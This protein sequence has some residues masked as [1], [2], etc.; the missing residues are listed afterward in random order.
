MRAL[1][2]LVLLAACQVDNGNSG[3]SC[4][5]TFGLYCEQ[6]QDGLTCTHPEE[7]GGT[8]TCHCSSGLWECNDCPD[9][10]APVG[11][12]ST[13]ASCSV[14]GFENACACSCDA[15]GQWSCAVDDPDPNFHCAP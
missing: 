2:V 1:A 12:C 14:W 15:Q 5:A 10:A 3:R 4:P 7:T 13:G 11:T 6:A 8:A 9:G